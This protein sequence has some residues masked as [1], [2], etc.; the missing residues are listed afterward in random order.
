M[1]SSFTQN[2]IVAF[3]KIVHN[4][5]EERL[6]KYYIKIS[7]MYLSLLTPPLGSIVEVS[8]RKSICK[9]EKHML[10]TNICEALE[11]RQFSY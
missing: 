1:N 11:F 2:S 8:T 3:V 9:E 5:N 10:L 6:K 7:L 4:I